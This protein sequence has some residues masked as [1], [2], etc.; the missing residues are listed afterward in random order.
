LQKANCLIIQILNQSVILLAG[1]N[2]GL[3]EIEFKLFPATLTHVPSPKMA[4]GHRR[5][6]LKWKFA[7][8]RRKVTSIILNFPTIKYAWYI[9][10]SVC[11]KVGKLTL[12]SAI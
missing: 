12:A 9:N 3:Y 10:R 1:I 2:P 11:Q 7:K 6:H 4:H 8:S 5:N